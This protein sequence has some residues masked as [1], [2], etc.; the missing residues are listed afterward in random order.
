MKGL[1][2]KA[3]TLFVL[4]LFVAPLAAW[5]QADLA[6][7]SASFNT[8]AIVTNTALQTGERYQVSFWLKNAGNAAASP[9]RVDIGMP[10]G[11]SFTGATFNGRSLT[12]TTPE[13][14]SC[15]TA[16]LNAGER[17][18]VT[19]SFTAGAITMSGS[20]KLMAIKATGETNSAN[21]SVTLNYF[22]RPDLAVSNAT[23][24]PLP[25]AV[26]EQYAIGYTIKNVGPVAVRYEELTIELKGNGGQFTIQSAT[27]GITF[28]S[29]PQ[30]SATL[31]AYPGWVDVGGIVSV[32]IYL[33]SHSAHTLTSTG[34][35]RCYDSQGKD[36]EK[37]TGDNSKSL[38]VTVQ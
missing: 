27:S 24:P 14:V 5:A 22:P 3:I 38:S 10:A 26:G 30:S 19:A 13:Y 23:Y 17:V 2:M 11:T 25:R 33:K 12:C 16:S 15:Q 28:P 7:E 36:W 32:T 1:F 34:T 6:I 8:Q 9:A 4:V 35:V 18:G 21:N 29:G 31:K 20:F 37:N